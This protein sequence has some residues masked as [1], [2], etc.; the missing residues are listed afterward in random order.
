MLAKVGDLRQVIDNDVRVIRMMDG[1]VLM[2]SLGLVKG[3]EG[4]DLGDNGPL[5]DFR[6]IELSDV[7]ARDALLIFVSEKDGGAIL[8]PRVRPL[9][10]QLC[11]IMGDGKK[12]L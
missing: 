2:V 11:G 3:F 4:D 1:V 10:I 8:R 5:K 7:S 9:P 6:L 12:H